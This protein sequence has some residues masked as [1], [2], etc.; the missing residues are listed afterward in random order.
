MSDNMNGEKQIGYIVGGALKANLNVR[1]TVPPQEV[2]LGSFVVAESSNWK[3]YSLVTDMQLG[4]TN[5]RFADEP[6][7]VRLPAGLSKLLHGQTLYT[8]LE[9]LPA[10]MLDTG[11]ELGTDAYAAWREAN[12]VDPHPMPV[13]TVPS[14]HSPVRLASA[15]DVKQVFGDPDA[16]NMFVIGHTREQGHPICIDLDEFV[17]RSAGIFGATG[18]GKSFLTRIILA[19]LL[20]YDQSSVLVFDMHNEYAYDSTSSDSG[21]RVTG[22]KSKFP[23]VRVVGV[24]PGADIKGNSPDFNLMLAESDIMPEDIE[25]LTNELNLKET[26]SATLDALVAQFGRENWFHA[27]KNMDPDRPGDDD[28][29]GETVEGWATEH[30]VNVMA[31]KALHHKLKRV[32]NRKYITERVAG[33][34]LGEIIK[35]LES[36]L[37]YVVSFGEFESSLDYLLISNLLTRRIRERWE[38]LTNDH[39]GHNKEKPRP[40][41]IVIEEAH[42]L[43]N[44]EMA[45]Q[46][47][48]STIARE[49]RKY[50]VTLLVVDQ[51]P[52]QIYDEVMSQLGTRISGWLGDDA[53]IAAVFSGLAGKEALRGMLT[54]L[55]KKQ[56]VLLL[57]WAVPMPIAVR[58]VYYDDTFWQNLIGKKGGESLEDYNSQLG[59]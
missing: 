28:L 10:L 24:G 2:Q 44:R 30:N 59:F 23:K 51:R 55:E 58:S 29:E 39:Q 56:E 36:G 5:A 35:G 15:G 3:F 48:F 26:T 40:L 18:T 14:H 13:K 43:L 50:Y 49:M 6:S 16:K 52:S 19:G 42:K 41:V 21:T 11:P 45:D 46:T 4:N 32:F 9:I 12:P 17:K 22:L 8:N 54:S 31:A 47:T 57:G 33:N 38:T 34:P 27:F 7:E 25:L 37:H 20:K 53:D 1:L